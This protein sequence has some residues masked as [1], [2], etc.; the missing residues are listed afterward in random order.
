MFGFNDSLHPRKNDLYF[1]QLFYARPWIRIGPYLIGIFFAELFLSIPKNGEEN[2]S[3]QTQMNRLNLSIKRSKILSW[4]LFLGALILINFSVFTTILPNRLINPL[5]N[6][7]SAIFNTLNK[8]IFVIGL[9]IILHLTYLQH[10]SLIKRFL[11]HSF[12][13]PIAR[14]SFGIYLFHFSVMIPYYAT[15][16]TDIYFRFND[17][18]FLSIGFFV[19]TIPVSLILGALFGSPVVV[20]TKMFT[21]Q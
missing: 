20:L 17:L 21:G 18:A 4:I 11:G 15:I 14:V 9:G 10:F 2:K 5:N 12:F 3:E 7:I 19:C 6:F 13:T 16:G 1:F 8:S